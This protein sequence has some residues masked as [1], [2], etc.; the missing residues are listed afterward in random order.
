[1][2]DSREGGNPGGRGMPRP[3]EVGDLADFDIRYLNLFR[4]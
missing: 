3:Y 2:V 1:M 4:I